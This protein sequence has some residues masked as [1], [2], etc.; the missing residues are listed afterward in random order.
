MGIAYT[1]ILQELEMSNFDK[2]RPACQWHDDSGW[3][4]LLRFLMVTFSYNYA[5]R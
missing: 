1:G 4:K 5:K 3:L 2:T